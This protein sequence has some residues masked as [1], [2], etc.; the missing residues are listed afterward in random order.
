[1]PNHEF[2]VYL[3][4]IRVPS[5]KFVAFFVVVVC[6]LYVSVFIRIPNVG[7]LVAVVVDM[8]CVSWWSLACLFVHFTGILPSHT[9]VTKLKH[10]QG[11]APNVFLS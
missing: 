7:F 10:I 8:S 6:I 2:L 3:F 11:Y 4:C 5:T 1:M 9:G